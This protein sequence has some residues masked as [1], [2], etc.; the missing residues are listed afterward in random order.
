M[1]YRIDTTQLGNQ[2]I[3]IDGW[4]NGISA[5]P[6]QGIANIQ[7]LNTSYYPGVAYSNYRR[8]ASVLSGIWYAGTHSVN[9]SGN[10]GWIFATSGGGTMTNPVQ[11]ATSPVGLNYV[12]DDSGQIWKQTSVN[13]SFF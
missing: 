5:S 9:V 1:A 3:V 4:E 11:K 6:Y 7:N 2:S 10:T 8:Q 12:L 13:S